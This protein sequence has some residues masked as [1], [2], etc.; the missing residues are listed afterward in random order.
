[1]KSMDGRCEVVLPETMIP[2]VSLVKWAYAVVSGR[3]MRCPHCAEAVKPQ[4]RVC[5]SCGLEIG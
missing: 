5:R 2:A 4:A 3:T 1:M